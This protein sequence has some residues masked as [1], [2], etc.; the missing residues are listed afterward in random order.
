MAGVEFID[1]T[2]QPETEGDLKDA[3]KAIENTMLKNMLKV[4]PELAVLL[5]TIR[6]ALIELLSIKKIIRKHKEKQNS[7]IKNV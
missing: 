5:P 2:R 6:R 3:L 7:G 1:K 4:P